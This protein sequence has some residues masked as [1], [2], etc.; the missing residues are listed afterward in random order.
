MRRCRQYRTSGLKATYSSGGRSAAKHLL[1][2]ANSY[3]NSTVLPGGRNFG[4]KA[5][6]R[7][8]KIKSAGRICGRTL[9]TFPKRDRRIFSK[10]VPYLLSSWE[11]C[12][13][14]FVKLAK[15]VPKLAGLFRCNGRK[16]IS[17]PGT[18]VTLALFGYRLE[19]VLCC[20]EVDGCKLMKIIIQ[21]HIL[22]GTPIIGNN[23]DPL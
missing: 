23:F 1:H 9:A 5:H 8:G 6:K 21:R 10:E 17:G 18:T 16:T 3:P 19:I 12:I 20:S 4:E 22:V 13:D 14:V 2:F 11:C 7:R 15:L